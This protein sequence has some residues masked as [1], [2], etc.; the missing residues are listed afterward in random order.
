MPIIEDTAKKTF[1]D[2]KWCKNFGGLLV[3]GAKNILLIV[4]RD[5]SKGV[6]TAGDIKTKKWN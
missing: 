6:M 2:L 1:F 3:V 5:R 4:L